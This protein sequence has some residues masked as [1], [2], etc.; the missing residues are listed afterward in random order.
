MLVTVY[1]GG[2]T[3]V[4][5]AALDVAIELGLPYGGWI[6]KG[7][8][9]EDGTIPAAYDSLRETDSVD[10]AVRTKRNV[11]DTDATLLLTFG[12]PYGGTLFTRDVAAKLGRP[13]M[14]LDL[15]S[16]N[17]DDSTP[18]IREWL[19]TLG[20][21]VRVN[22]AGP[23]ASQAPDAYERARELLLAALRA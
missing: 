23:R 3:G 4:D 1:S 19:R 18:K 7:R 21:Q 6:P 16:V 2:Q 22:V 15:A 20:A 5:R 14:E 8:L 10:Y 13:M 17:I 9:A 12:P 11:R